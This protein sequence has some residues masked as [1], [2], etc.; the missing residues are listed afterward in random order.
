MPTNEAAVPAVR[1]MAVTTADHDIASVKNAAAEAARVQIDDPAPRS[2]RP[3]PPPRHETEQIPVGGPVW[4]GW[5]ECT[6][7]RAKELE[8]LSA[9]V[10]ES[11]P[12]EGCEVLRESIWVPY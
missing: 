2:P 9:W 10:Y 3:A 1:A 7:T 12:R 6:L 4:V 8:A 11:N 5:R